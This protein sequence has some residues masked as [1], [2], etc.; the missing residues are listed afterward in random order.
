VDDTAAGEDEGG[1][2]VPSVA[3]A[4]QSASEEP[5]GQQPLFTQ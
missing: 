1:A 3:E 4:S 2:I 5:F